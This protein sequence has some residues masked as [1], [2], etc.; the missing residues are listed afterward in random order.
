M[1]RYKSRNIVV[2]SNSLYKENMRKRGVKLIRHFTTP[3]LKHIT[4][5]EISS[6]DVVGHI[7]ALGDRF[8]K[9]AF[10]YYGDSE[11]WWVIAWYNKKPTEFEIANGETIFIPLPL[12]RVLE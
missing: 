10:K 6:L 9:L 4:E 1:S 11:K 5:E 3:A 7:W 8:Y 2:N 12:D